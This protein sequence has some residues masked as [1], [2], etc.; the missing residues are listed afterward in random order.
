M[1]TQLK[2]HVPEKYH[3]RIKVAVTQ[4]CPL[5]VKLDLTKDGYSS[6]LLTPG[7]V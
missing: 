4:D 6:V 5:V 1:Y 7:Q 3:D 2:V